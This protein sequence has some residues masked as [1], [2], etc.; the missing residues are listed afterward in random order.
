MLNGNGALKRCIEFTGYVFIPAIVASVIVLAI[1]IVVFMT[2]E[3]PVE[4]PELIIQT[5]MPQLEQNPLMKTIP[6]ITNILGLWTAYIGIFGIKHARNISTIAA[7][8]TV[9]DPVV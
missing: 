9:S 6:I 3:F 5:L 4:S 8:I 7:L 2:I 1:T